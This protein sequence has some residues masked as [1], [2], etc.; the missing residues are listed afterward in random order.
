MITTRPVRSRRDLKKFIRFPWKIYQNDPAWVPPLIQERLQILSRRKNPFFEH[1]EAEYFLAERNG[2]VVGRLSAHID[3]L[4]NQTHKEKTGFFGFFESVDDFDV[5]SS[6]LNAAARWL[7]DRGMALL[8]GPCSFTMNEEPGILIEGHQYPPFLMMAHNPPYYAS[9]VENSG[10]KKIKDLYAWRYDPTKPLPEAPLQIAEEVKKYPGLRIREVSIKNLGRE[11]PI[12]M[13]IVNAA[14]KENWGFVPLTAN[15]V[16]KIA[17]DFK[18]ILDPKV[19]LFAEVNGDPAAICF[20]VPNLNEAIKDLNGRLFP[21]GIFKLLYRLKRKKFRSGR[22]AFLG[23]KK[24]YRGSVLG[25][26]SVLLYVEIHR[27]SK[28]RGHQTAE[29]SWTLED[30]QKINAG[31]EF[32]GGERYKTYR[33]YERTI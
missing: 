17:K 22:L 27:A 32:M 4:H 15:E 18:R 21:F 19:A 33:V 30:N 13:E 23:V 31:I 25:G 6:L 9:L 20:G 24:E 29:L 12:F 26:L 16:Q 5:A 8:R 14:W 11:L 2:E 28:E 3:H 10:L 1:A 7:K